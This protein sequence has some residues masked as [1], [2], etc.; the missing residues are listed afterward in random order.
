MLVELN[1][2]LIGGRAYRRI[3][4]C[5]DADVLRYIIQRALGETPDELIPVR[6]STQRDVYA[7]REGRLK[8]IHGLEA[9]QSVPGVMEISWRVTIGDAVKPATDNDDM[10]GYI[11]TVGSTGEEAARQA[12][13]ALS[14]LEIEVH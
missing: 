14:L 13:I 11:I 6:A 7:H 1:A 3:N 10:L 8:A 4:T 2:R 5:C 9:A 12:N